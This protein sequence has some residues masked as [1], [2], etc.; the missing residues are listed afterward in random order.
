MN[1]PKISKRLLAA[2]SLARE[3]VKIADV[4]TDHAY[5][6]I[7][8]FTSGRVSGGVV[9]DINRGPVER[10]RANLC[11]YGCEGAFAALQT[12][13]LSG[14]EEYAPEDIFILGMGGELIA[15]IISDAPWVK[16]AGVR[17]ILQPMTHPE[18]L[19]DYLS[20]EGFEINNELLVHED[21]IYH[22]ICAE[23][24]GKRTEL[25]AFEALFGKGN[26]SEPSEELYAL[27]TRTR[28]IYSQRVA[29]KMLSGA[30]ADYENEIIEKIDEFM[31]KENGK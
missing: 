19:R 24:S 10:A 4:G 28:E 9:S 25:D 18:L 15:R 5:L 14:I 16:K 21:K 11:D 20:Q 30:D 26:L 13:G 6:P 7:Y 2:A 8:L 29:G 23:Y 12:D 31:K 1:V 22:I 27:L 3:G 17:L